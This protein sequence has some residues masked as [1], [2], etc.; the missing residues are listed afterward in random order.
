MGAGHQFGRP[1]FNRRILGEVEDLNEVEFGAEDMVGVVMPMLR[2]HGTFYMM[3][4]GK[5][6]QTGMAAQQ[7][8]HDADHLWIEQHVL[9]EPVLKED[10]AGRVGE[11]NVFEVGLGHAVGDVAGV[12]RDLAFQIVA[13]AAV[14]LVRHDAP[15]QQMTFAAEIEHF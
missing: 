11:A 14:D 1:Q 7:G 5:H 2:R 8:A 3:V 6:G 15:Q 12:G 10:R 13:G 4:A 9:N